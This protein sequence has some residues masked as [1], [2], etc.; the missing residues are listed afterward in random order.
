MRKLVFNLPQKRDGTEYFSDRCRM[1]PNRF[2][3]GWGLKETQS[4]RQCLS[5]FLLEDALEE[6]IGTCKNEKNREQDIV[7][8]VEH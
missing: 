7:E 8:M 2:F 3:K 4:L 1:N 6:N 5:K